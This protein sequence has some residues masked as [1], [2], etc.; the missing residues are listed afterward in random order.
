MFLDLFLLWLVGLFTPKEDPY[1]PIQKSTVQDTSM[2]YLILHDLDHG[3]QKTDFSEFHT[4]SNDFN[5]NDCS[6]G[7]DWDD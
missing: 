4:D 1:T 5:H 6:E 3:K 2:G 7:C